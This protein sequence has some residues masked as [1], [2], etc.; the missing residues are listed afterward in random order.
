MFKYLCDFANVES[1]VVEGHAANGSKRISTSLGEKA[2]NHAWNALWIDNKPY[3]LDV[4]WASGY[5]DKGVKIF[6]RQLNEYYY[7][8]PPEDMILDH[9]PKNAK[10]QFLAFPVGMKRFAAIANGQ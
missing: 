7:L 1:I 9:H 5:C 4:T 6:T 10:W 2:S 8:T 3:L